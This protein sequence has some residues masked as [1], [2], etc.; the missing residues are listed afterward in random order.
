M[1]AQEENNLRADI[2]EEVDQMVDAKE[3]DQRASAKD[4]HQRAIAVT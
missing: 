4:E 2:E 1:D 3:E